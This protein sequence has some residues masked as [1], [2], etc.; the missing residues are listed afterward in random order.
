[1]S[2]FGKLCEV[3]EPDVTFLTLE[4][5][6]ANRVLNTTFPSEEEDDVFK[7]ATLRRGRLDKTQ[8]PVFCMYD[9]VAELGKDV[10][11]APA[12][13]DTVLTCGEPEASSTA[14]IWARH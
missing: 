11:K 1:M 2:S 13:V 4:M 10:L 9:P 7:G 6:M 5:A 14:A 12:G 8:V 3:T